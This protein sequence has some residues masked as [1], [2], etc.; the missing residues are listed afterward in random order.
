MQKTL[1]YELYTTS[2]IPFIFILAILIARYN[3]GYLLFHSLAEISSILI[4]L[5]IISIVSYAYQFTKNNFLLYLG[6]GYFWVAILDLFHM[7]TFPGISI[8]IIQNSNITL[9]FWIA[10]RLLEAFVLLSAIFVNFQKVSKYMVFIFFALLT[11]SIYSLAFSQYVPILYE[12]GSGL[13]SLKINTEYI[14]ISILIITIFIYT[15]KK[16][17]FDISI[18]YYIM[19]SIVL[20]IFTELTLTFYAKVDDSFTMLAHLFKFLSYWMIF[21]SIIKTSLEKPFKL[22]AHDSSTYNSIPFPSILVDREGIIRQINDSTE[23]FLNLEKE[24]IINGNNHLLFH[25]Q[26]IKESECEVCK[27]IKNAE[28]LLSYSLEKEASTYSFTINKVSMKDITLGSVQVCIDIS[29]QAQLESEKAETQERVKLLTESSKDGIWDWNLLTNEL[30]FSPTWKEQLGYRDDEL[31]SSFES[32]EDNVHPDDKEEAVIGFTKNIEGK[33]DYYENTHRLRHK[34]GS[35]VWVLDRGK[36]T[37]DKNGKAVRMVGF[38]TDITQIKELEFKLKDN[39]KALLLESEKLK[40]SEQQL[41]TLVSNLPGMAYRTKNNTEWSILFLSDNCKKLTGYEVNNLISFTQV[42]HVDDQE[43]VWNIIQNALKIKKSYEIEYRILMAN[44]SE[45]WVWEKGIGVFENNN[46]LYLE[47]IILDNDKRKRAEQALSKNEKILNLIIDKSPIGICTV[48]LLG[49]LV[50]TNPTYENMLGY[51]K[52]EL[53]LLSV[54]DITHPD[55]SSKNIELYKKMFSVEGVG[56]S[57][58]KVY[59]CKDGKEIDVS[60]HA[61][62]VRDETGDMKFGTAFVEDITEKK[63]ALEL[64]EQKKKELET[65]IQESP[66]PMMIHNEDGKVLM[67][68]KT[69]EALTGYSYKDIDTIEKWTYL[70]YGEKMSVIK[71]QID[72]LYKLKQK[73]EE[74]QYDIITKSGNIITWQFGS[75]PLGVIDSKRTIIS[76]AMDITELK[77]KDEMLINQ[78]RLAAMGEMIGMIA[79]QWR[80]PIS[81][82]AM[83]ANNMLLD[84]ALEDFNTIQ[85]EKYANSITHQTKHLSDT[86]DDFRNFFKPDKVI[87]KVNIKEAIDSTLNIVKDSLR[88]NSI[89]LKTFYETD[90]KVDAYPREL[91]QVF[92]NIITNS[93]DALMLKEQDNALITIVVNE[94]EKYINI[95][96]CDNGGG[97][98]ADVLPK[99]FDPYFSTKDDKTGTGIG[100]Y[101]SKMIIENHLNGAIEAYNR[102]EGACFIVRLLK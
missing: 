73:V 86:I 22:L 72:N 100:L 75:A 63:H 16:K 58:E 13:T 19:A 84:I 69:W 97:I 40:L 5:M 15:K 11:L 18:Y 96:I 25:E 55:Y 81:S 66:S 87:S 49:N 51:T 98:D 39:Q 27:A 67:V 3:G 93:K 47:G 7:L 80:Q 24:K 50:S 79:H 28:T 101:M 21:L 102:D 31:K 4:G 38:H 33:T 30:Y 88:N 82:I 76:S 65:I 95:E 46:L 32:W 9:T 45:K 44:G 12:Q 91:M 37:F 94:D 60:V 52:K 74:G 78:S 62:G 10:A 2:L 68:N 57:M 85:A 43:Y 29:K 48:D 17:N 99:V 20:T 92:V 64:L 23:S 56:F 6:I 42:I 14:I 41:T 59:I 53:S 36:T 35:W 70:A 89:E 26:N 34:D 83:D 8:Y 77:H 90:R 54:F 1:K 61:T 71:E